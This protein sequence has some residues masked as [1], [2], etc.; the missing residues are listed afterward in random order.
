MVDETEVLAK[1]TALLR[2]GE[3]D[4]QKLLQTVVDQ[5]ALLL[6]VPR[7]SAW[8]F[9][10]SRTRLAAGAR[11][12]MPLHHK[13]DFGYQLG[14]GLIGWIAEHCETIRLPNAEDDA[15]FLP[16]PGRV[17]PL[18]SFIGVPLVSTKRCTG[19]LS[20]VAPEVGYF[21]RHHEQLLTVVA[22]ICADR[23]E[24]ARRT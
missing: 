13:P 3:D 16:R 19:V 17:E 10:E 1:L 18:K 14:Q 7:V 24:L 2:E 6:G 23:L 22:G 12:G 20:A 4:V 21:S 9:D 15:R 8:L 11:A 5:T